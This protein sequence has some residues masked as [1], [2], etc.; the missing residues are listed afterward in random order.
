MK[1]RRPSARSPAARTPRAPSSL[2]PRPAKVAITAHGLRVGDREIPI[3]A[4]AMHYW[5]L[6]REAWR[7][8]MKELHALGLPIVETYVPWQVHEIAPGNYDFGRVDPKKDLRAFVELAQELGLFVFL[9]P[10]PHINS[11]MTWFGLPERIVYDKACQARSPS[12]GP[13]VLAFPPRMFPVPSYASRTYFTEVA[14]WYEAVAD[15]VRD[16][17]YPNGPIVLLQ[18]DNEASYYFRDA[19]Y[20]Q[21]YHPDAIEQ[22]RDWVIAR[23]GSIEEAAR[24]HRASYTKREDITPPTRFEPTEGTEERPAWDALAVHLD[25]A[26]FREDLITRAIKEFKEM[27]ANVGLTGVPTTH[28]LPLGEISSPTSLPDLEDVVDLVGLD[29]YHAR[30]EH[31]VVKRRTLYLAGTSRLPIAPELGV[32][33]PPW[34]TPLSHED[35]LYTAMVAYAYGLRGMCLYMA[36]DRDRWYGAPIDAQGNPRLE[37]AGWKRLIHALETTAFHTLVRRTPVAILLPREYMR[38]SRATHLLGPFTPVTVEAIG[39][40]P[41]EASSED[42]L[43]FE[44][45]IQVLWWKMVARFAEALSA[46]NVP[47]V[48]LDGDVPEARLRSFRAII[49]PSF[50]FASPQRWRAITQF[51]ADGGLVVHGPAMPRLD[52]TFTPRPFEVPRDAQRVLVDRD[53]DAFAAVDALIARA[54]ELVLDVTASPSAI[55]VTV[56][57]DG[58]GAPRVIFVMNPTKEAVRAVVTRSGAWGDSGTGHSWKLEDRMSG[59]RFTFGTSVELSL[60]AASLRMLEV[61][62]GPREDAREMG[63]TG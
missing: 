29:Y 20:D 48:L 22:L 9:R 26:A 24:A 39:M 47:Y 27:L 6:D 10:G 62:E 51:A 30:R 59:E 46:R 18:V 14:R 37:A 12:Q 36:V 53:E 7:P 61:I 42:E 40:S 63:R 3:H 15:E 38:L 54:P 21:D 55:E 2:P 43:G 13:V 35:S 25:W 4:G 50:D 52:E 45:P 32:G 58:R 11:E 60:P 1:P 31:R 57:E 44:G 8:A 34:F 23:H 56:H 5:R 17:I 49:V 28:N 41:V 16:L 19:P 33:A